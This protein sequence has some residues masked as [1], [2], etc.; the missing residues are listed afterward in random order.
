MLPAYY[1]LGIGLVLCALLAAVLLAPQALGMRRGAGAGRCC[2]WFLAQQ[3]HGD[4]TDA[5]RMA[6]NFYG[7]L[8]TMDTRRDDTADDVRQLYH[9]SVK[10]G[11][12]YLAPARRREPTDLLRRHVRHRP[13]DRRGAAGPAPRRPDRPGRRHAGGLR[14]PGDVYR[15]YE[16]NP[17][18]FELAEREF[19]FL[20]DSAARIERVLGDA[21][22]ALERET[23]QGFDVLAVD[24]FSGDSMPVHLITAEAHGCLSA[25]HAAR[26]ASSPST[27]PTASSRSRRWSRRSRSAKGLHAAL[28]DDEP[29]NIAT[30]DAP[31]GCWWRAIRSGCC[32][33]RSAAR[34]PRSS[35][36]RA[37]GPGPTTSTTF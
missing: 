24:A 11:E 4:M 34:R 35:P 36:Y 31:T 17:Q 26:A 23:P 22:L 12:Q 29:Q 21:R 33:S 7:T 27:S 9:G 30:C 18:V 3:V 37:F 14:P 19:S 28:V 10:H 8:L 32:A 6:R 16:I 5:R 15:F 13:R 1:E 25:P 2:A 20:A